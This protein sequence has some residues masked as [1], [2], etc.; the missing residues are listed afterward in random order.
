MKASWLLL[1]PWLGALKP[2]RNKLVLGFIFSLLAAFS[3]IGLLALSG[4]FIT[5]S[6]FAGVLGLG[7]LVNIYTPGAGIRLFAVTR[8]VGRYFERLVQHDAVL[9]IQTLWRVKLFKQ[10]SQRDVRWLHGQQTS[11]LI[12]RLTRNLDVLDLLWLR[13]ITP[14]TSAA[15]LTTAVLL[16]IAIWAPMLA[17]GAMFI[18][19]LIGLVGVVLPLRLSAQFS[20]Q[21]QQA[22]ETTRRLA[23][24]F[25]DGLPELVAWGLGEEYQRQLLTQHKLFAQVRQRRLRGVYI[26]QSVTLVLH[27]LLVLFAALVSVYLWLQMQLSGPVAVMLPITVLALSDL[28]LPLAT[29]ANTWGDILYAAKQL[30]GLTPQLNKDPQQQE[31]P[32]QKGQSTADGLV[33]APVYLEQRQ[34]VLVDMASWHVPRGMHVAV[35]AP[36]GVGKSS[37]ADHI[38][39]LIQ[40]ETVGVFWQGHLLSELTET[41]RTGLIS[42]LS[43]RN[44]IVNGTLWENL[45]LAKPALTEEDA[46]QVLHWVALDTWAQDLPN[47]LDTWL[48]EQGELMSGGQARRLAL[49]R[50]LLTEPELAL[51][52]E[53]FTGVDSATQALVKNRM[54]SWLQQRTVI[55]FAH[56]TRVLPGTHQQYRLEDKELLKFSTKGLD[57]GSNKHP[58]GV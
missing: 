14:L 25:V 44:H 26:C 30:N 20:Q 29:Q 8:T 34:R 40:T 49:A 16:F 38:A 43:Q 5:A 2:A 41:K 4:W 27:Q 47:R 35:C 19:L 55:Y 45:R 10:L 57:D 37:L 3:G 18:V 22:D 33:L 23:L 39:G 11:L 51:F 53:P 58:R 12:H 31:M 6:A 48:G 9:K 42:Y 1:K 32:V 28:I 36:S 21:E 7:L 15:L 54:Q 24:D 13:F 17:L 56:D 46:W 52:D 50:V